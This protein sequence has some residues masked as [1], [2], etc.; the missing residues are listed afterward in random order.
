MKEYEK[1]SS[2]PLS[3]PSCVLPSAAI[4]LAIK[5]LGVHK[6]LSN[7]ISE[8][9]CLLCILSLKKFLFLFVS[10]FP[11]PPLLL[12]LSPFLN[13]CLYLN[14]SYSY[15]IQKI[16]WDSP[17]EFSC[18]YVVGNYKSPESLLTINCFQRFYIFKGNFSYKI[19]T[20]HPKK[21]NYGL[22]FRKKLP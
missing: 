7:F 19:S 14:I 2:S 4:L 10:F 11:P 20:S 8:D 22:L 5:C 17:D 3:F 21:I 13:H 12:P 15:I 1:H 18:H 6:F 16:Y 9:V